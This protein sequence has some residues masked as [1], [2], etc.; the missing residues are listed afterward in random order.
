MAN[1][2]VNKVVIDGVTK[3]DLTGDTVT[4]GDLRQGVTAHGADG[5]PITGS[6]VV[7]DP[8][9][10]TLAITGNGTYDVA[11]Y[12]SANVDVPAPRAPKSGVVFIDYDGT[13]IEVWDTASVASKTALPANPTGHTRL[14]AEGW[15][16]TLNDIK[17]Y[18]ASFPKAV[19]TVGQTYHTVS[20]MTEFDI[21]VARGY[22]E[23]TCNMGGSKDWGDGTTDTETSHTYTTHGN[24]TIK[25]SGTE[26]GQDIFKY[27]YKN[28]SMCIAAFIGSG[29]TSIPDTAFKGCR[30]LA[31]VAIPNGVTLIGYDAFYQCYSLASVAIPNGV[32]II[33]SQMFYFCYLLAS[34]SIPNGVSRIYNNAFRYCYSLT[35]IAIPDSIISISTYVF[36]QCYSLTSIT[37]PSGV[38]TIDSYVFYQCYSIR[39]YDFSQ[40]SRVPSLSNTNAFTDMAILCKIIVPDALYDSWRRATNWTTYLDRIYKASEVTD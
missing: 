12:A 2:Y 32:T 11:Q 39:K 5:A 4:A 36:Y 26:L 10:G 27:G 34:V 23:V 6:L 22:L 20:G 18:I 17:S 31:S 16:W 7:P 13:L 24:Y 38:T 29:V 35:S 33:N 9:S 28:A 37:I 21:T 8:P 3:I 30:S 15:N 40:A 25:C 19:L 14:V 1:Q